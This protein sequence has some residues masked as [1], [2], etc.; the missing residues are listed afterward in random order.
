MS[1]EKKDE[2]ASQI[3]SK[4]YR[5]T[6]DLKTLNESLT[7]KNEELKQFNFMIAHDLKEPIRSIVVF[8]K[9]LGQHT[10][11]NQTLKL[12]TDIIQKS[13]TQINDL[14]NDFKMF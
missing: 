9:L 6:N 4:V 5:K 10:T 11:D 8:T 14:V 13:G 3:E 1:V 12:Y 2:Y 7:L